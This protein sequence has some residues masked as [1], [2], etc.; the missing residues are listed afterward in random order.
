MTIDL[1]AYFRRIGY[2]GPTTPG[3]ESLRALALHHARAIAFENLDP[4]MGRPV[5][6]EAEALQRKLVESGRGGY[7]YEHGLIL[8]D[9]LGALGFEV[10]GLAARVIK[11]LPPGGDR[12][13]TH[14]LLAVRIGDEDFI[15][16]V[17]FG[18]AALTAPL[19]LEPDIEQQT[20]HEPYRILR[21]DDQFELQVK[22][23]GTWE[24]LYRFDLQQQS[25]A[26]YEMRNYYTSTHPASP[27]VTDLMV[28]R[29]D[30]G[31]RHTLR[32]AMYALRR[33]DGSSERRRLGTVEEMRAVLEGEFRIALP[34]GGDLDAALA[35]IL[36]R[37]GAPDG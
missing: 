36:A 31:C 1:E 30:Q 9:V 23:G 2:V 25:R 20:P 24:R 33:P 28:A 21:V 8:G 18:I 32:N 29:A 34:G 4:L 22:V 5:R 6:L 11:D 37:A 16:D 15:A 13:R 3:L 7:C 27:F 12:A 35:R 10:T 14:M 17:G 19:R 26:D